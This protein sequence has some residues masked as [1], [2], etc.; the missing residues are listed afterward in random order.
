MH[1]ASMDV[2]L[3]EFNFPEYYS[4]VSD[5]V[6]GMSRDILAHAAHLVSSDSARMV[7]DTGQRR[8]VL[9]TS[10]TGISWT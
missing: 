4:K 5:I 10:H 6:A 2:N 1:D 7:V 9:V 8:G 3:L